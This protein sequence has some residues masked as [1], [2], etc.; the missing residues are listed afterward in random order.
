MRHPSAH[1][2]YALRMCLAYA[3]YH[4]L[5]P[6]LLLPSS[7]SLVRPHCPLTVHIA[8]TFHTQRHITCIYPY[9]PLI[10]TNITKT[11]II[12]QHHK[13]LLILPKSHHF[14]SSAVLTSFLTAS[15]HTRVF[16]LTRPYLL[17]QHPHKNKT[18]DAQRKQHSHL[19]VVSPNRRHIYSLSQ[20]HTPST[21]YPVSTTVHYVLSGLRP[22]SS[23]CKQSTK[24]TTAAY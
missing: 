13:A 22:P 18:T 2:R 6:P 23:P 19:P 9:T 24:P 8:H 10:I 5:L 16:Y 7:M 14:F 17:Q 11:Q 21:T 12:T 4:L 15:L 1:A 20:R 3:M